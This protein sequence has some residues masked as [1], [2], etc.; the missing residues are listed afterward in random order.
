MFKILPIRNL[1]QSISHYLSVHGSCF[2][3]QTPLTDP[4]MLCTFCNS[5]LQKIH[6]A[7]VCCSLPL[8][9][10]QSQRCGN[11]I[12]KPPSYDKIYTNYVFIEPLRSLI[13]QYKYHQA[14]HLRQLLLQWLLQAWSP[15]M[16]SAEC[17]IPVPMH[18]TRLKQ[19]GFNQAHE[20]AKLL[21]K[22]LN[23]PF[24]SFLCT[25]NKA[26]LSVSRN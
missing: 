8:A 11:C 10:N 15:E 7:C 2:L 14:L 17:I 22:H 13:H 24:T 21:A 1:W 3:C 26:T 20:L 12:K 4:S 25:K 6:Y 23:L 16:Q 5:L 9:P 19:R 18:S